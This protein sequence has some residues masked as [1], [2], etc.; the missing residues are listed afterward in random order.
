MIIGDSVEFMGYDF[1]VKDIQ[2]HSAK[3]HPY[4]VLGYLQE[5]TYPRAVIQQSGFPIAQ[6]LLISKES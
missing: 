6:C 1:I 3:S 5:V 2:I 4:I